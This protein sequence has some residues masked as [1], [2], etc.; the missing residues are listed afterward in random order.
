VVRLR[1]SLLHSEP[2]RVSM[3]PLL[4]VSSGS[5]D[6]ESSAVIATSADGG[7]PGDHVQLLTRQDGQW[8]AIG[9]GILDPDGSVQFKVTPSK[10]HTKYVVV[11]Q[12]TASH[13]A[14]R[15]SI[16]VTIDE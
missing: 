8:V 9:E 4:S 14:S 7:Q 6:A 2:W 16:R 3:H 11:L 15:A 12:P 13:T 5:G 1:S 10:R